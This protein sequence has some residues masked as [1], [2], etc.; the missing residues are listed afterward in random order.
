MPHVAVVTDTTPLPAARDSSP[1]TASHEVSLYVNDGERAEREADIV[2]FDAFYERPAHGRRS[3][4]P[5]RSRRSATSSR[6]TSRSLRDGRDIVS[7][8]I[9][10][11]IS[12]TVEAAAQAAAEL[13]EH[14]AARDRGH[15]LA[16]RL[17][18]RSAWSCSP[19]RGGRARRRRRR[20]P[21]PRAPARRARRHAAC[22]SRS[23]R[24]STCGAAGASA[25]PRRG[26]A[27]R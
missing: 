22:G 25:P 23:T 2:D 15:R 16:S 12:G 6:S 8:H 17:R 10:G 26:S 21:S 7:I 1:S 24:S 13:A 19:P 4:R 27:A 18:R 14:A 3:C 20:R 5:P 11:G 9:S